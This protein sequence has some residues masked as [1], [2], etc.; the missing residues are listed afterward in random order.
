[1]KLR[2]C[3]PIIRTDNQAPPGMP[4]GVVKTEM[5]SIRKVLT[6]ED[7]T[8]DLNSGI[9]FVEVQLQELLKM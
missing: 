2:S 9:S 3:F 8:S 7:T 5:E 1:M 6:L 4:G